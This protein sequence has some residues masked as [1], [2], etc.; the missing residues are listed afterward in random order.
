MP[1][2]SKASQVASLANDIVSV[3]DFG[4]V[5]DGV[6]DDTVAIQAAIDWVNNLG[7]GIVVVPRNIYLASGIIIKGSVALKGEGK[8]STIFKPSQTGYIFKLL[9]NHSEIHDV[10]FLHD[11][12]FDCDAIVVESPL[13]PS[14]PNS[15]NRWNIIRNIHAYKIAGSV[16]R[17]NNTAWEQQVVNV[18]ARACGNNVSLKADFHI[19]SVV[20]NSDATNNITFRDCKSIFNH[21]KG[22]W[23]QGDSTLPIRKLRIEDCMFH[24][25]TDENDLTTF[26]YPQIAFDF[27]ENYWLLNNNLTVGNSTVPNI[28]IAGSAGSKTADGTISGNTIASDGTSGTAIRLRDCIETNIGANFYNAY[29]SGLHLDID[30]TNAR[31]YVAK[32]F[33]QGNAT[34]NIT[35]AASDRFGYILSS[36]V[37]NPVTVYNETLQTPT[38]LGVPKINGCVNW[39]KEAAVSGTATLTVT[40]PSTE[41]NTNYHVQVTTNFNCGGAYVTG[42]TT[43]S[44]IVNFPITG[45]GVVFC[46]VTR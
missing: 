6:T 7:G 13:G 38:L 1:Q 16:I 19:V 8:N 3:K 28:S 12:S 26:P 29:S 32:Q 31:V 40:L 23:A 11:R 10:G 30:A 39:S 18:M 43:T 24:G 15:I 14:E 20:T 9:S 33:I 46:L 4:A 27:V 44:F 25:G 5:G 41:P 22:F 2:I 36:G 34:F 35:N 21:Y 37:N 17:F 45:T 42:K